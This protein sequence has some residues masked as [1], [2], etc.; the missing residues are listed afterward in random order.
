MFYVQIFDY[1][2]ACKRSKAF[3]TKTLALIYARAIKNR[4]N[5][6][7]VFTPNEVIHIQ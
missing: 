4:Y 2:T 3:D 5:E 6:V 1:L 7:K